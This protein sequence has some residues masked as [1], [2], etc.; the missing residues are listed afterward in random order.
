MVP[1][2]SVSLFDF[3]II[4][5]YEVLSFLHSLETYNINNTYE[6][7][8]RSIIKMACTVNTSSNTNDENN[9]TQ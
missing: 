5:D 6:H 8:K 7:E 9:G 2:K 1:T 4:T 3:V